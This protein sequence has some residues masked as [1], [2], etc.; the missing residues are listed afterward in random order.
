M[1]DC[2]R[3]IS[4]GGQGRGLMVIATLLLLLTA[5]QLRADPTDLDQGFGSLGLTVTNVDNADLT[6]MTLVPI[7]GGRYAIVGIIRDRFESSDRHGIAV[8]IYNTDG[9]L[10]TIH[11]VQGLGGVMVERPA[12]WFVGIPNN[13]RID[14]LQLNAESAAYHERNGVPG[15]V[16]GVRVSVT[17][18]VTLNPAVYNLLLR[19][20][21]A[22][23]A[24]LVRLG[25]LDPGFGTSGYIRTVAQTLSSSAQNFLQGVAVDSAQRILVL[26]DALESGQP[27]ARV[28][29]ERRLA[30]GALDNTWGISGAQVLETPMRPPGR[31]LMIGA[32]DS[33]HVIA[34]R[35]ETPYTDLAFARLDDE[36]ALDTAYGT[37]GHT[38]VRF[39][40]FVQTLG[41]AVFD[42]AGRL[43]FTGTGYMARL[44][45]NGLFD[46]GF[47]GAIDGVED[48][49]YNLVADVIFSCSIA[50]QSD[51]RIIAARN[52]GGFLL[53]YRML[54]DTLE[55][56]ETF[57]DPLSSGPYMVDPFGE[58]NI[59]NRTFECLDLHVQADGRIVVAGRQGYNSFEP[60]QSEPPLSGFAL[61][62][63]EGGELPPPAATATLG[64][65]QAAMLVNEDAGTVSLQVT[66]S[67]LLDDTVSVAYQ[68]LAGTASAGSDFTAVSGTLT[69]E[70]GVTQREIIVPVLNDFDEL[71]EPDK[72]FSV[73]LSAPSVNA[74]IADGLDVAVVTI[75]DAVA[76]LILVDSIF[77]PNDRLIDYGIVG[78][79]DRVTATLEIRNGTPTSSPRTLN[80]SVNL[81][82]GSNLAFE[83]ESNT[84]VSLVPTAAGVCSLVIAVEPL[85]AGSIGGAIEIHFEDAAEPGYN[86]VATVELQALASNDADLEVAVSLTNLPAQ[87]IAD[88][89]AFFTVEVL[90][91]GPVPVNNPRVTITFDPEYYDGIGPEPQF[92]TVPVERLSDGIYAWDTG[93]L[94]ANGV[95]LLDIQTRLRLPGQAQQAIAYVRAA[96]ALV[97][98]MDPGTSDPVFAN[99]EDEAFVVIGG[100]DYRLFEETRFSNA[101][102]IRRSQLE[103][104][105]GL[106]NRGPEPGRTYL[107]HYALITFNADLSDLEND[108]REGGFEVWHFCGSPF[109]EQT[110]DLT[111]PDPLICRITPTSQSSLDDGEA[112]VRE[113][114]ITIRYVGSRL[115]GREQVRLRYT[116]EL[117]VREEF[118]GELLSPPED[119]NL[120]N[121]S[122]TSEMIMSKDNWEESSS[123]WALSPWW[124]AVLM[125]WGIR[126]TMLR[127]RRSRGK[128]A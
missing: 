87:K 111:S 63:L 95:A 97:P 126:G 121:N 101:D 54:D 36:G 102:G 26:S 20:Q 4:R 113:D 99:N 70:P 42:P 89:L 7:P 24:Q 49:F 71:P 84:C 16:V 79:N 65:D 122:F 94:A 115:L 27:Q 17:D 120:V 3:T 68:T 18:T 43:L 14:D 45:A 77:P 41:K 73:L 103:I 56:D 55:Q 116:M 22:D 98:D 108:G 37:N 100:S 127:A 28:Q 47:S 21:L 125:L 109:N 67:G 118:D 105:I 72:E 25:F 91:R 2:V 88:D 8:A 66:R 15:I 59:A 107:G 90:N 30:D 124:L 82:S 119:M 117:R 85:T 61:I 60:G 38:F 29:V 50:V 75:R 86:G 6:P 12:G 110:F 114:V 104:D 44:L 35:V 81:S 64:F 57:V 58:L 9:I 69:F 46:S 52:G 80:V 96:V 74:T 19:F 53:I 40:G 13:Q 48:G 34:S 112:V 1:K 31:K 78:V 123:S 83:I 76:P 33:V 128:G 39:G 11:G 51:G 106:E 10:E 62:R 5:P 23:D 92:G 32:G 93:P